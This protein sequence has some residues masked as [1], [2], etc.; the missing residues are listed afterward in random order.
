LTINN[1]NSNYDETY[2]KVNNV[3]G[4]EPEKI[5]IDYIDRIDNTKPVLDL[6]AGQGRN[7][8]F[9]ANRNF[10]VDAIDTSKVVIEQLQNEVDHKGLKINCRCSSF[11][12][13]KIQ[14]EYYSAILIFGLFQI[15]D[16][17]EF[18]SLINKSKNWIGKNGLVFITA[19]GLQDV[20]FKNYKN[21]WIEEESNRFTNGKGDYRYFLEPNELLK[22]YSELNVIHYWE[23]LGKLHKHG[24]NPPEQHYMVESVFQKN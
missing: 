2:S 17:T 18:D 23:G 20:S 6:G 21:K 8:V 24:D 4:A 5:L 19:F 1:S 12:E 3:F 7:S 16:K 10:S 22:I 13:L 15:L 9:V 11:D 14:S